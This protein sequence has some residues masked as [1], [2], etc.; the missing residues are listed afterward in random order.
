MTAANNPLS[1]Y[2]DRQFI[3]PSVCWLSY[4]FKNRNWWIVPKGGPFGA[5]QHNSQAFAQQFL[6]NHRHPHVPNK[7]I[8][9]ATQ[10]NILYWRWFNAPSLWRSSASLW[11]VSRVPMSQWHTNRSTTLQRSGKRRIRCDTKETITCFFR[12][13]HPVYA[14]LS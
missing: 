10:E 8:W 13:A 2:Q 12:Q 1:C 6:W 5:T 4:Y 14:L 9:L 7:A 11:I 3:F